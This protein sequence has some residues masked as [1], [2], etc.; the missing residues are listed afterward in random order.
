MTGETGKSIENH[1]TMLKLCL[2]KL[3][4]IIYL[5]NNSGSLWKIIEN[6][7]PTKEKETQIY[8]KDIKL[9]TDDF[10]L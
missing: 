3:R 8:M 2:R 4:E 9:V 6:T 10:N 7:I 5:I 1:V